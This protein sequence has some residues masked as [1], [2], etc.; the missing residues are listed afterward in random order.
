[1][2]SPLY[3]TMM[4]QLTRMPFALAVT[5]ALAAALYD[6]VGDMRLSREDILK[7]QDI[8]TEEVEVPEW[9]GSVLVRGLTGAQRDEFEASNLEKRGKNYV[10]NIANIRAK[11]VSWCVVD[12]NGIPLFTRDDIEELGKKSGSALSRVYEVAARLSGLSDDD[13]EELAGNFGGTISGASSSNSPTTS[14]KRSGSS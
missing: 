5:T 13:I 6:T 11:L 2:A 12:D 9:G 3:D 8:R 10:P 14:T 7:S 4:A 1:M